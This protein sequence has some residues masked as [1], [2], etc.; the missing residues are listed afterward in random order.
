MYI[1]AQ[2]CFLA[3][4]SVYIRSDRIIAGARTYRGSSFLSYIRNQHCFLL[5]WTRFPHV[6]SSY[7]NGQT[8]GNVLETALL[9]PLHGHDVQNT[10]TAYL[11]SPL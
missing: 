8:D 2:K 7:D 9:R 6:S 1:G 3:F 4:K 10:L 5:S 11:D